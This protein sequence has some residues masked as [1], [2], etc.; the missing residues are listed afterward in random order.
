MIR[1]PAMAADREPPLVSVV[2][3]SRN[4]ASYIDE[5]LRSAR[6]QTLE[7]VEILVVDDGST[8]DTRARAAHH[9]AEDPRVVVL[10]GPGRGPG[11]ARNVALAAARGSW[12][13][14]LDADDAMHPRRLE[15]LLA[16]ADAESADIIADNLLLFHALPAPR[17]P[18]LLLTGDAWRDCR[19][20]DLTTYIANNALFSLGQPL[21]YLKPIIRR[22]LVEDPSSRYDETLRIGEDYD[23]L[24]RLLVAGAHYH[25]VPTPF[26]FYRRHWQSTSFRMSLTDIE[27]LIAASDR[28]HDRLRDDSASAASATR[29]RTL[30]RAAHFTA[31]L[32]H[33]KAGRWAGAAAVLAANP[34]ALPLL[35]DATRATVRRRLRERFGRE[36]RSAAAPL[37][38]AM[39]LWREEPEPLTLLESLADQGWAT[40]CVR[41]PPAGLSEGRG[42][43]LPAELILSLATAGPL[44]Q[45]HCGPGIDPLD[46]A[47]A[48][49]PEAAVSTYGRRRPL[50]S[51]RQHL[52]AEPPRQPPQKPRI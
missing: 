1:A 4:A 19:R 36:R 46:A 32:E 20:I 48:L 27:A 24:A 52:A 7:S 13:A 14:I 31:A 17:A 49:S 45:L 39:V 42:V 5:A 35:L 34:A 12:I 26:Y 37:R 23:L 8:D 50:Q 40:Q 16:V 15:R 28:L 22:R 29:R 44:D 47:Y 3:A 33:L 38:R 2:V 25:Y 41:F 18:A 51:P 30:A 21:G 6:G 11:A 9:A 10:D 43:A